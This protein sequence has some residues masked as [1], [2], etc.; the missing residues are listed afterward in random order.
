MNTHIYKTAELDMNN[1]R[2]KAMCSPKCI[3]GNSV[4]QP[5]HKRNYRL[6]QMQIINRSHCIH[7][8]SSHSTAYFRILLTND[9]LD[10]LYKGNWMLFFYHKSINYLIVEEY[11]HKYWSLG[12]LTQIWT[13]T[14]VKGW[15]VIQINVHCVSNY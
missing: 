11:V 1:L 13:I 14:N 9:A 12:Q 4:S 8:V 7:Y 15:Q 6:H 3:W 2:Y 10:F 5:L